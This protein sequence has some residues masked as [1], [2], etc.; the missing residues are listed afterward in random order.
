MKYYNIRQAFFL[1]SSTIK[2]EETR[3]ID[4]FLRLIEESGVCELIET[5][6]KRDYEKGGRPSFNPYDL[7]AAI[8]YSFGFSKATLRN[9]EDL[10]NYDLRLIYIMQNEIPS[11]K[12]I[13]NFIND[14]IVPNRDIIFSKLTNAIFKAC[15]LAM[16]KAYIDGSKFE[17][18][19]N[20]YKFV[21]KPTTFHLKLCEKIRGLLHEYNID[22][23]ILSK[24]IISSEQIA[25]K[26]TE[27]YETIKEFDLTDKLNKKHRVAYENMINYL[28]KS[29]EYEEKERIC[30][31]NRN[32]YYKTDHDATAMCLKEDY[33]SG[34]GSN[35][36]A[37]YN[38]QL[39]VIY[40][41]I[42][43]FI[44][45]QSRHDSGDFI[46]ILKKHYSMYQNYPKAVCAD[47]GYGNMENYTFL[48][49][50]S[51]E[52][53]VKHF[54]WQGNVSGRNPTQYRV[55]NDNTITC[56]SGRI[57]F[58]CK[59]ANL[60]NR[61][62]NSKFYKIE[63]C[64]SCEYSDYCKRFMKDK[65]NNFKFF[66]VVVELQS[67]IQEAENNLL[68]SRGIEMRVNRSAQVEGAF[69]IIKQ[70]LNYTRFRRTSLEKVSTEFML[71]C[72]GYNLRK[73][74]KFLS[75]NAKFQ[76]WKA[77]ENLKPET[78]KKPSAK[79]LSNK[80]NRMKKKSLNEQTKLSY[81]YK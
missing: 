38:V 63:G 10:C 15:H 68:S 36:H 52:N 43:S 79:R 44:V 71:V 80:A 49:E 70:D 22:R 73:Y 40:G 45:T 24:G 39:C 76:Y 75:G 28:N 46:D 11:Y 3:K 2:V 47:S 64:T 55:N 21:W 62:P 13:G 65:T 33:Y 57:G 25:Q 31:P 8:I 20:K 51:I 67:F 30:G 26:L 1:L 17:A 12:T 81:K 23:G 69:G 42:S 14:F 60:H 74:F 9:I 35:M 18:N 54:T 66:E 61:K 53:Y 34:L 37:G 72:L 78:F 50:N 5:S 41:I 29:L 16:D 58:E 56:L 32:S 48:K 7:F 4:D 77:P 19:C 27:L 59:E 6:I